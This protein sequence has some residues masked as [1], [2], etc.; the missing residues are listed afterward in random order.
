MVGDLMGGNVQVDIG[1]GRGWLA[2]A[3]AASIRRIDQQLGRLADINDAGRSAEVADDNYRKWLAYKNGTGP[4]A[5]YALPSWLSVHCDGFAADSDDWYNP[6]AAAVWRDN[7]WVQTA[8]YDDDRDEPW[9]GEYFAHLDNHINDPE[10]DMFTDD[11]RRM[12]REAHEAAMWSKQRIGGSTKG[13]SLAAAL[14]DVG[15][16][17]DRIGGTTKG[18]FQSVS[19][20]LGRLINKTDA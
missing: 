9:H 14:A 17:K 20:L 2:P 18:A 15:W 8:R 6:G 11:D 7:G 10:D 4:W 3:P 5:P 1:G 13:K 12:L 16:I 19:D